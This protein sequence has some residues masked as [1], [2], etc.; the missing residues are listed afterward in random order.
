MFLYCCGKN[1]KLMYASGVRKMLISR[2]LFLSMNII[3]VF[4][5]IPQR[6]ER[7]EIDS[8]IKDL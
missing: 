8:K 7:E 4:I 5:L 6:I 1:F 2:F 3:R